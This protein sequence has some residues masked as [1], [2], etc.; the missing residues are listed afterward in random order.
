MAESRTKQDKGRGLFYMVLR[1]G[2]TNTVTD[3]QRLK[4]VGS[5]GVVR[6][7]DP[8]LLSPLYSI[9]SFLI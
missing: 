9:L 1:K 5:R 2:L 6:G 8:G 4:K 3:E 7:Y